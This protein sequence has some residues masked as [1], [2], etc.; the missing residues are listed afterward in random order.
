[1]THTFSLLRVM[2]QVAFRNLWLHKV[3]TLFMGGILVFGS[4]LIVFGLSLLRN[5]EETMKDGIVHSVAGHL[6]VYSKNARDSLSLFGSSFMG[7]EDLGEISDYAVLR[8]KLMEDPNVEQVVPMGFEMALLGRGNEADELID[9]LRAA[10]KNRDPSEIEEKIEGVRFFFANLKKELLE[11]RKLAADQTQTLADLALI[12][13]GEDPK[14]WQQLR[15]NPEDNLQFLETKIAP[16]SG[17]KPWVYLRYLGTNPQLF[18]KTFEKFKIVEGQMIPAGQR[19]IL[20]SS[21]FR[22]D[23]LKILSARKFDAIYKKVVKTHLKI[24][25]DPELQ[26]YAKELALQYRAIVMQL[27]KARSQELT[28]GLAQYF[29]QEKVAFDEKSTLLDLLKIFLQVDDSNFVSR[30]DWFY[31]H[32]APK[33]RLYEISTN[34]TIIL[35]SYTKSGYLK[36]VPVKVYGVYSF[37][38]LEDSDIAGVFN[39][40]DLI[41]FR[42]L[43]GHMT[44]ESLKEIANIR[45]NMTAKDIDRSSAE[46][47][48]FGE[49][50]VIETDKVP[51]TPATVSAEDS[52]AYRGVPDVYD[53]QSLE[54]GLIIN[55]AVF[56]KDESRISKTTQ[57]LTQSLSSMPVQIVD[58]QK[59]SGIVGQFVEILRYVLIFG[60]G[61][62]LLVALVIINNSF[63]VATFERSKEIGTMRA[64]GAQRSFVGALFVLEAV[65][66]SIFASSLGT[67]LALGVLTWLSEVGIP[68]VHDVI[69]FLFSGPRLYPVLYERY[70]VLGPIIVTLLAAISSLY[71]AWFASRVQPAQA[72]Q[73]KE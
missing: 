69:V 5:V 52:E 6:Q 63:M 42:E 17:E 30:H 47:E 66:L 46:D 50:A 14:F 72:M 38:G 53:P 15:Q 70:F 31:A 32:I 73:E 26:R 22:E 21:K 28:Q 65:A 10:L 13:R 7:K 56:L 71:P 25:T 44:E 43:F 11:R 4:F 59:A 34:E 2:L 24:A 35:R 16:L 54:T 36:S 1:M 37:T 29:H 8:S 58:W 20:L 39:V 51:E 19:G 68:A 67:L 40:M 64:F 60:V 33:L 61:I 9:S 49:S 62:I 27:N 55:A 41:S 48:L 12:E 18:Q 23:F 45:Q 3:K 57:E